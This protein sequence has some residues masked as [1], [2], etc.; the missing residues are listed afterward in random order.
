VKEIEAEQYQFE[1]IRWWLS[2]P[3]LKDDA[4]E[5][6]PTPGPALQAAAD[7]SDEED[8]IQ[9]RTAWLESLTSE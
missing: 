9:E 8:A 6:Y 5:P 2:A 7:E 1:Q 4:R 3:N